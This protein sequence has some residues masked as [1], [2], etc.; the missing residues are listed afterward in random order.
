MKTAIAITALVAGLL[1][2]AFFSKDPETVGMC[3]VGA[4][5]MI[6]VGLFASLRR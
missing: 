1:T 5:L 4:M 2:A 6:S 3:V